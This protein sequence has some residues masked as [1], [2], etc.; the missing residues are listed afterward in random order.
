MYDIMGLHGKAI[1]YN[2]SYK[3]RAIFTHPSLRRTEIPLRNSTVLLVFELCVC[4]IEQSIDVMS[5]LSS[6]EAD[7]SRR[8]RN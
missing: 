7:M 6:C 1:L 4:A 2:R 3:A 5:E 8:T